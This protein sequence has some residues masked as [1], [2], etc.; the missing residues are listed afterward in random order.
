MLIKKK[1]EKKTYEE[2]PSLIGNGDDY[3]CYHMTKKDILTAFFLGTGIVFVVSWLFFRSVIF[4][5]VAAA[6]GGCYAQSIYQK[7]RLEKRKKALLFQF[8]DLLET[9]TSSYSAGKNTL[10]A[11]TD[12]END[13]E[14]I[15]GETADII[16][17]LRIIVGGMQNNLN[18]EALLMNFAD[19]SGLDDVRNFADVFRVAVRQGANIKDIIFST[20]DIISDKI[21]IE[22]DINTIM[23]GNKNELNIMMVMPLVII[24]S[25]GGMG[26][27]MTAVSNSPINILIKII[28]L[29]LFFLAYC[30]GKKFTTIEI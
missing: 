18:I 23:S 25:L 16:E 8:K 6:A 29:G 4:S 19:R 13:L 10:E 11:F 7:Y 26:S 28:A 1:K 15:Y 22:M 14:Q 9:L 12:A 27:S 30:L 21:E 17:E 5:A 2:I 24:V 20:R 3:H